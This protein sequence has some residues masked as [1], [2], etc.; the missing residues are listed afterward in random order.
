MDNAAIEAILKIAALVVALGILHRFGLGC[1]RL[2]R[3]I[4]DTFDLVNHELR[5][6]S[7]GSLY[8]AIRRIDDRVE[9]LESIDRRSYGRRSSDITEETHHADA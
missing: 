8:D 3:A 4:H 1:Y 7:G 2:T 9:V 6:N 5:P